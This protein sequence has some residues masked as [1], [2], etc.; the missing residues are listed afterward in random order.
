MDNKDRSHNI[1]IDSFHGGIHSSTGHSPGGRC[2]LGRAFYFNI[3]P[4]KMRPE[5]MPMRRAE[6]KS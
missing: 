2:M 4:E 6:K 5:L 3:N 1:I